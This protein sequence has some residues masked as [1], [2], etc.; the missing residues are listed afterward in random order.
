MDLTDEDIAHI[1][2]LV[3]ESTFEEL[4]IEWKGLVV[5][6]SK[7]GAL[8]TIERRPLAEERRPTAEERRAS[9]EPVRAAVPTPVPAAQAAKAQPALPEGCME[10]KAPVMGTFYRRPEPGKPPFVEV[11]TSVKADDTVGLLEVMKVFTAVKAEVAGVIEA[12]LVEDAQLAEFG[13]GLF[14]IRP[15]ATR[16]ATSGKK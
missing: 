6:V 2:R 9:V 1:L 7:S 10:I 8:G 3:D 13:Q 12:V 11:G 14:Q 5:R 4:E 15:A 16:Q